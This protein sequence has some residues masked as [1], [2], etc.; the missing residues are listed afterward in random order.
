MSD[1]L[2]LDL[3]TAE[4]VL[5][6]SY[7]STYFLRRGVEENPKRVA[8]IV[9]SFWGQPI[10]DEIDPFFFEHVMSAAD[11][12][13]T[14][15][16]FI[17]PL[18]FHVVVDGDEPWAGPAPY[19]PEDRQP[20]P[21]LERLLEEEAEI[22]RLT[23]A[24][25]RAADANVLAEYKDFGIDKLRKAS[26]GKLSGGYSLRKEELIRQLIIAGVTPAEVAAQ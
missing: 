12:V 23:S 16:D 18:D 13:E 4:L 3:E 19:L 5:K 10:V 21:E 20:D 22:E 6:A 26:R 25:N 2:T 14:L 7:P 17:S 8:N 15:A 1:T 11:I 24:M 9:L